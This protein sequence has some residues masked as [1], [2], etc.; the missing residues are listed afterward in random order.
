MQQFGST[1]IVSVQVSMGFPLSHMHQYQAIE[2]SPTMELRVRFNVQI[3][4]MLTGGSEAAR[5]D[6][7]I[8]EFK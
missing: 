8:R 5:R 6:D 2:L 4:R 7:P 1:P 3:I